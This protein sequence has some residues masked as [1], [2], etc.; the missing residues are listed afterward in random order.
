MKYWI[1]PN[2]LD[3]LGMGICVFILFSI[4]LTPKEIDETMNI[5]LLGVAVGIMGAM[6]GAASMYRHSHLK[7]I[8]KK[9]GLW[10]DEEIRKR[11]LPK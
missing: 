8:L 2:M 10:Q 4:Y 7:R 9:H 6:L 11:D 3:F 5:A 1:I